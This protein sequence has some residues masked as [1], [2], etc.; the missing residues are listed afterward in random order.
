[1]TI[2]CVFVIFLST[3]ELKS[4]AI[5]KFNNPCVVLGWC[6]LAVVQF[7]FSLLLAVTELPLSHCWHTHDA[8][9]SCQI[10]G[11][12]VLDLLSHASP[13]I[14]ISEASWYKSFCLLS[15]TFRSE[16]MC[17]I[18][19]KETPLNKEQTSIFCKDAY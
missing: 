7:C 10:L 3:K 16:Q 12:D 19:L 9:T 13:L 17:Q 2:K 18:N 5:E 14:H 6:V 11:V 15:E 4:V 1:M 8:S